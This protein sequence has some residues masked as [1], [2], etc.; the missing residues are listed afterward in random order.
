MGFRGRDQQM[1][2]PLPDLDRSPLKIVSL[3]GCRAVYY[4]PL[5]LLTGL[6][7]PNFTV[8]GK[9]PYK[10][11]IGLINEAVQCRE[12][13]LMVD[14]SLPGIPYLPWHGRVIRI[15]TRLACQHFIIAR[16]CVCHSSRGK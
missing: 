10:G 9:S 6:T 2:W 8:P 16:L 7:L 3:R 11:L 5:E 4:I 1:N 12:V 13:P 15:I 14:S